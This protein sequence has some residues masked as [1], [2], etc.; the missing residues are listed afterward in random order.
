MNVIAWIFTGLAAGLLVSH[1]HPGTKAQG[2]TAACLIGIA[3]ALIGGWT[4]TSLLPAHSTAGL[5]SVVSALGA[6]AIAALLLAASY[7]LTRRSGATPGA[8]LLPPLQPPRPS[9]ASR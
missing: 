1:L 8:G 5:V 3:G 7:R 6:L 2:R 4:A 9:R